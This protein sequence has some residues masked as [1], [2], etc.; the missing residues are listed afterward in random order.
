[1]QKLP[2]SDLAASPGV[3]A[4]NPDLFPPEPAADIPPMPAKVAAQAEWE[5][6]IAVEAELTGRGY[7]RMTP[8]L[9][10]AS[11]RGKIAPKGFYAHWVDCERNP[12]MA[13]LLVISWPVPRPPLL[14]ELKVRNSFTPGQKQAC[15]LGLWK[16][17]WS[18]PEAQAIISEWEGVTP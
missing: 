3:R 13:D 15:T 10:D 5:L 9:L 8:A 16:L 12:T 6:Q 2:I 4:L 14:L 18:L 1:M 7:Y 11:I 17:A